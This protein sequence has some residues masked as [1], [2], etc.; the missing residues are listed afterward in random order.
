[1]GCGSSTKVTHQGQQKKPIPASGAVGMLTPG[2]LNPADMEI[3]M[4]VSVGMET[5]IVRED[6]S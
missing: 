3:S 5:E 1:M 6:L 4:E 2:Q